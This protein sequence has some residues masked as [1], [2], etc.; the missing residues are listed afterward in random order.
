MT[1]DR[2][3]SPVPEACLS[4]PYSSSQKGGTLI[5]AEVFDLATHERRLEDLEAYRPAACPRCD[6][7]LHVHDL[8]PR[9]LRS[10]PEG[11]TE[12]VRFRCADR[13]GCGAA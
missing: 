4:R 8:R 6:A 12:V 11:A 3:L 7:A 13:A 9:V 10:E 5:A 1:D 2:S